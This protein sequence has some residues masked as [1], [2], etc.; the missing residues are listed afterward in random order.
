VIKEAIY[1]VVALQSFTRITI[2][3]LPTLLK[4]HIWAIFVHGW[5]YF[6]GYYFHGYI[7]I[8]HLRDAPFDLKGGAWELGSGDIL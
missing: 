3:V 1:P 8:N 7:G 6:I 5:C 4:V 2:K